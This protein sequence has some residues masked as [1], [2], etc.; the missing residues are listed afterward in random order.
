[1]L[2]NDNSSN[3]KKINGTNTMKSISLRILWLLYWGFR[4]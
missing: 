4:V 2:K 3:H 1:M